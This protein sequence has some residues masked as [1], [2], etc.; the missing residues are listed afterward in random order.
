MI[1]GA[2]VS[3]DYSATTAE[4]LQLDSRLYD[5]F[6]DGTSVL[7]DRG[8]RRLDRASGTAT[9]QLQGNGWRFEA[10]HRI[11]I[12]IAQDDHP[13]LKFS[14]VPSSATLTHVTLRI[15]TL[16]RQP[17]VRSDFKNGAKFCEAQREFMGDGAFAAA[18][19]TG[20]G[21]NAFGKCVS[22]DAHAG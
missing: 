22:G 19:G 8:P 17:P 6:P 5:V 18:Y 16:E 3:I 15:P 4:A 9:Y 10:G 2:V 1:G 13:F 14:T 11:R 7:V 20:K 21:A 12:E